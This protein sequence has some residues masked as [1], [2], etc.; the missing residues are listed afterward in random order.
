RADPRTIGLTVEHGAQDDRPARYDEGRVL[1]VQKW[2]VPLRVK[3]SRV[4]NRVV[5]DQEQRVESASFQLFLDAG[6]PDVLQFVARIEDRLVPGDGHRTI[7]KSSSVAVPGNAPRLG[8]TAYVQSPVCSTG[9][10]RSS[11]MT[12]SCGA[13]ISSSTA[14]KGSVTVPR[15]CPVVTS[16][17]S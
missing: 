13:T 4:T 16:S 10:V 11:A 5:L 14:P 3:P 6:D 9:I 8:M 7:S 2:T 12:P 15:S 1:D 17:P